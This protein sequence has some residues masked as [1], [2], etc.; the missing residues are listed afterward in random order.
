M[1]EDL[2]Y[3]LSVLLTLTAYGV[4]FWLLLKVVE[5]AYWVY[6]KLTGRDY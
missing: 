3:L 1:S 5:G 6:C 4:G 2:G